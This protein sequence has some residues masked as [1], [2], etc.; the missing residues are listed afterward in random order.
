[1]IKSW[2]NYR[3]KVPGGRK[4]SPLD[5][6]HVD[7]WDADWTTEFVDL[8]TVLTRLVELEPAQAEMLARV[9]EGPLAS[10]DDL[11]AAGVRWPK[12]AKDRRPRY[13]VS[14]SPDASAD[15]GQ[16]DLDEGSTHRA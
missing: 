2:F 16:L 13:A 12:N 6:I 10:S 5:D 1:M 7:T 8:L 14:V 9:L 3:K 4:S 11:A 15:G